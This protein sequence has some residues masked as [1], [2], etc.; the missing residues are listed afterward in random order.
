MFCVCIAAPHV[1][2]LLS[3]VVTVLPRCNPRTWQSDVRQQILSNVGHASTAG[4][5][6][7][8]GNTCEFGNV[9]PGFC[10][11]KG[12]FCTFLASQNYGLPAGCTDDASCEEGNQPQSDPGSDRCC[13]DA[14]GMVDLI[15]STVSAEMDAMVTFFSYFQ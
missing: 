15:C 11:D 4:A 3:T 9:S 6:E 12:D 1:I 5:C 2:K 13:D 10:D 14:R 8:V 7:A